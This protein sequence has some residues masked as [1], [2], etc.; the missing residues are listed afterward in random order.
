LPQTTSPT[1]TSFTAESDV[2]WL[3]DECVA[4]RLVDLMRKDGSD[5]LY[6][7]AGTGGTD[8]AVIR[9]AERTGCF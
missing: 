9:R 8:D 7:A 5:V 6:I 4:A 3:A 2:R 1:K